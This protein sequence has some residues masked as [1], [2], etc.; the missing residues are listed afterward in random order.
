MK[1][2]F[3]CGQNKYEGPVAYLG[4]AAWVGLAPCTSPVLV[5]LTFAAHVL[6]SSVMSM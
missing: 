6:V 3:T 4:L 2:K 5:I 1:R